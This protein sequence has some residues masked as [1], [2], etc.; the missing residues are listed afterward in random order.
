MTKKIKEFEVK[1]KKEVVESITCDLCGITHYEDDNIC[2][3]NLF[4]S[5]DWTAGYDSKFDMT[6]FKLDMCDD[7]INKLAKTKKNHLE[8]N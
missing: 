6:N 3:E 7:C 1:V 8:N 2:L 5:I 4:A